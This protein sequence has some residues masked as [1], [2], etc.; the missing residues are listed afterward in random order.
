MNTA[1]RWPQF[2]WF[3][4]LYRALG[5]LP[6][7]QPFPSQ[8][9]LEGLSSSAKITFDNHQVPKIEALSATDA[10]LAQGYLHG[11][12][13]GFQ[14]DF[15]RRMPAGELS[16]LLGPDTVPYDLFMRRLNLRH[17]AEES[18]KAWSEEARQ[19]VMAYTTGVNQAFAEHPAPEYRFLKLKPR[20]WDPLDTLLLTYFLSW[21]LNSIWTSKWAYDQVGQN[22]EVYA[23]LF[24]RIADTPDITIIPNTGIPM[25]WGGIG[26]GS[27]NWVVSGRHTRS[28]RPL[29]AN[30]PHLMPQLPSIWFPVQLQGSHL[31]VQG[32]S[33]PGAPGV[34]IGQNSHI[35]WGVT[36]VEPDCQDLFRI[37][38]EDHTS[39]QLDNEQATLQIRQ[40]V[41]RVRG[42]RDQVVPMED[43]HAGP[44][45]HQEAD[46]SRIALHWTGFGP[47]TTLNALTKL[48]RA[49]N[50]EDFRDAL[51]EWT[52]P[53][54]NFVYA[55]A[56]GHIGYQLA[57][58]VPL[59]AGGPHLGVANGNTRSTL[60]SEKLPFDNL[61]H[62]FDPEDG[63]IVTANNAAAGAE[64]HPFLARN[65]LGY[66]ARRIRDL[67]ASSGQHDI[68]SF[69][70]IQTDVLSEPLRRLAQ[71]LLVD[72]DTPEDWRPIL[73]GFDGQARV[74]SP[75]PTLLY[76]FAQAAV[77]TTVENALNRPLF[78]AVKGTAPGTLPFPD[79]FWGLMGER[80]MP[81]VIQH[82]QSLN[83]L[84]AC[85]RATDRGRAAFG[86]NL[87]RMDLGAG[88]PNPVVSSVHASQSGATYFWRETHPRTR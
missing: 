8:L 14:M 61:P 75:V 16:E 10:Y 88:S 79:N 68:A 4:I 54:Q 76:L 60:A 12:L 25:S 17:W 2:S 20:P 81:L 11:R 18:R 35:A 71:L 84:E 13:R 34:I 59:H 50:W 73:K 48:N 49:Q 38:M 87:G 86:P 23:W 58:V 85:Q 80:L 44:I 22:P 82:F 9:T 74:E 19:A 52:I 78:P 46:G 62:L 47:V 83:R 63:I 15:Y 69:A 24:D 70:A 6:P 1:E 40:E 57:G 33:L 28:G 21:S 56:D 77:P 26:I 65:S 42:Q 64:G 41:I 31:N 72:G 36:N 51:K 5:M 43:S 27:N 29:L 7:E 30:D 37:A 55:D 32:V 67:L 39:Y 3:R 45:I 53:A 66:R